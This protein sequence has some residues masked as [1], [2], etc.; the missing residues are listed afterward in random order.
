M[1]DD[2]GTEGEIYIHV[3]Q[4]KEQ[5]HTHPCFFTQGTPAHAYCCELRVVFYLEL[6]WQRGHNS[7]SPILK[8]CTCSQVEVILGGQV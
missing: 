6:L 7:S 1:I 4:E 3:P 5:K 8:A 2:K